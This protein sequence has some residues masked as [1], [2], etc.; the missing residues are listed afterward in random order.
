MWTLYL[1]RDHTG[2]SNVVMLENTMQLTVIKQ[3]VRHTSGEG[4]E[5]GIRNKTEM[6]EAQTN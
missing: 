3:T 1:C 5:K 2:S 4:K 6:H